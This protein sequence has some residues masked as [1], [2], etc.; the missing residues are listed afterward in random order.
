MP[1]SSG[2]IIAAEIADEA[3]FPVQDPV[4]RRI[5]LTR[6]ELEVVDT[7]SFQRLRRVSQLGLAD[8]V[9]PGATRTRFSH[10][11]G[12]THVMSQLL[13][14]QK[15]LLAEHLKNSAGMNWQALR[16]AA[17]LHDVGHLPFSHPT[18]VAYGQAT[19]ALQA[20]QADGLFDRAALFPQSHAKTHEMLSQEILEDTSGEIRK[21]LEKH[22]PGETISMIT[23]L[24]LGRATRSAVATALVSSDLDA[25]RLD[26]VMR[27]AH[28]AGFVYGL[29][30][31]EYLLENVEVASTEQKVDVLATNSRHGM[32]ALEHYLLARSFVYSQ[33]VNHKTVAAA[34]L[35]LRATL[36]Q[37]LEEQTSFGDKVLPADFD[38]VRDVF[39]TGQLHRLTDGFV[40]AAL[41]RIA[42]ETGEASRQL[43]E[44]IRRLYARRLPKLA[45]AQIALRA[46]GDGLPAHMV[47]LQTLIRTKASKQELADEADA[48]GPATVLP[49]HFCLV[50]RDERILDKFAPPS[51]TGSDV[52]APRGAMVAVDGRVGRE[53][54]PLATRDDSLLAPIEGYVREIQYVF[55]LED[56]S[57][58]PKE[59]PRKDQLAAALAAHGF[60]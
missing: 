12:A 40:L 27:D 21:T 51:A 38:E 25:D 6:A 35:L 52:S 33:L 8:F 44:L 15:G 31:L 42:F 58:M 24:I 59:K 46:P 47:K 32:G 36:I 18:E 29:I 45:L 20:S 56:L 7:A 11:L 9:F 10:S 17:L 39:S 3:V 22:L 14:A 13:T 34:E 54:V 2:P 55:V 53:A 30:D 1:G 57:G 50:T 43:S 28:S 48:L 19:M 23:Q 49:E 26:Y 60:G 5:W 4:H 41:G 16:F 37:A